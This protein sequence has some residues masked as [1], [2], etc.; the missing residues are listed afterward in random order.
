MLGIESPLTLAQKGKHVHD[1]P[2][3][4]RNDRGTLEV[5]VVRSFTT[6]LPTVLIDWCFGI[7]CAAFS[8]LEWPGLVLP[9]LCTGDCAAMLRC[10]L[11]RAS[12]LYRGRPGSR[13]PVEAFIKIVTRCPNRWRLISSLPFPDWTRDQLTG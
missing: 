7:L 12:V 13:Q 6:L 8:L 4:H 1:W 2:L 9:E 5:G 10:D 11:S 3:Q